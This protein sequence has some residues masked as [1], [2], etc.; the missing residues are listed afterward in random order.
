MRAVGW[1]SMSRAGVALW[2]DR[3]DEAISQYRMLE[4]QA[5]ERG[6]D[7]SIPAVLTHLALAEF[8]AGRWLDAETSATRG[9]EAA[10]QA[11]ERQH[12]AIA[13]AAQALVRACTGR[14]ADARAY[15]ERA[16]EITGERS[17][18]LARIHAQWALALVDLA[19]GDPTDA[20]ARL[21]PLRTQ[22]VAAGVGEPGAILF[23]SDEIEAL[24]AAGDLEAAAEA[25]DWLEERGRALDRAS[26]LAGALA[27]AGCSRPRPVIRR[28]RST[29]SRARSLSTGG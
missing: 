13:L 7:G 12:E 16:R 2:T 4:R 29:R 24:V 6:D 8:V 20:A 26:A 3:Q 9:S 23:V 27:A 17:V 14:A 19:L 15:A 11:G 22:L 21:G 1:P 25:A 18:A 10:V 5:G 28:P